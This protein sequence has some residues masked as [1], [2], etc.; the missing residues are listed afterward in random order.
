META[1]QL[2]VPEILEETD[3][4]FEPF[5]LPEP[6]IDFA[7]DDRYDAWRIDALEGNSRVERTVDSFVRNELVLDGPVSPAPAPRGEVR[8]QAKRE[9][10]ARDARQPASRPTPGPERIPGPPDSDP[11]PIESACDP[12]AYPARAARRKLTG[13]VYVWIDVAADGTVSDARVDRSS[14]HSI[15]DDAALRA[16]R[17]WRFAPAVRNGGPIAMR[18]RKPIEF[19]LNS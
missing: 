19:K 18:V 9:S 2:D 12:P 7:L 11:V 6:A 13:T 4:I 3:P 1:A 8:P 10:D 17:K 14:G 15:L 16:V 5:D